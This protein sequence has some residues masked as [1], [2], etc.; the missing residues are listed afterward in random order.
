M[1]NQKIPLWESGQIP[2]YDEKCHYGENQEACTLTPYL[3][4]DGK[5]HPA[6]IVFPGGG[7]VKHSQKEGEPVANYLNSLGLHAFVLNYRV[8]PYPPDLGV[9]DGKRAIRVIRAYA[10]AYHILENAIGVMGFSAGATNACMAT[11]TYHQQDYDTLDTID[12]LSARPDFCVLAYGALSFNPKYMSTKD[13]E[14]FKKM[15]PEEDKEEFIKTYSCDQHVRMDMPPIFVWHAIDDERVKVGACIDF[16]KSLQEKGVPFECHL[17]PTG[18][19]GTGILE[20]LDIPGICQWPAL[21]ENW[22]KRNGFL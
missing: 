19:H 21:F 2:F 6:I 18:G 12:A 13:I 20:A 7:F 14:I 1:K 22:M 9:V 5:E 8:I 3:L 16:V 15:V 17:F 10:K 4:E 11:E